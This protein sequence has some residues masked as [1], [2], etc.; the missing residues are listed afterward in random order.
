MALMQGFPPAIPDR[1]T[2][3]NWR[4]Q[5]WSSWAFHHVR[6]V[7]PSAEIRNAPGDVW[8]LEAGA[9]L[10]DPAEIEAAVEGT[11]TDALVVLHKGRVVHELYRNGM[12]ADDPHILM[13]VSKSVLGLLAGVLADRGLLDVDAPLSDYIPELDGTA[14]DGASVR[15]ALDMQVGLSFSED[16]TATG[17][18]I[19][20]YRKAAN[21]NPVEPGDTPMDLRS[22]QLTLADR[23]GPHGERFHYV[24]PVT[25]LMA[26]VMERATGTRYADLVSEFLLQPM[27][28][29]RPGY[30][31]VDRIGGARAAGGMCLTAR[32]LARIG[33]LVADGGRRGDGRQVL[34][35][36]WVADIFDNGD[37]AAWKKGDFEE[38]YPGADMHYRAKCYVLRGER[39]LL[40]GVGIHG[41]Y[42]FADPVRGL[43]VAW[44]ASEADAST[45]GY[46]KGRLALVDKLRAA[47]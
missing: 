10:I 38:N 32:D 6:E 4:Q 29:E 19:I 11:R 36:D 1:A 18:P 30:V 33:A 9:P 5:P 15:Q 46:F 20:D 35:A 37:V 21:W 31:T 28:A 12:T 26:W 14:Y 40:R 44:F 8:A 3:A 16:Y 22:F 43:S 41:Q 23:E 45:S 42:L 7:V 13:S 39:P 24:S 47:C 25:D 27:G 2:L 34:P 17:G